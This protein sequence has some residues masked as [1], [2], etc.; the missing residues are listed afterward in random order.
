VT[1]REWTGAAKNVDAA[2]L[3]GLKALNLARHQVDVKVLGEKPS[4]LFSLFGFKQMEVRLTVKPGAL[5]ERDRFD[6][7][8]DRFR[9]R[10]RDGRSGR[11]DGDDRFE[12]RPRRG[13]KPRDRDDRANTKPQRQGQNNNRPD[14]PQKNDGRPK[15]TP[16]PQEKQRDGRDKPRNDRKPQPPRKDNRPPADTGA[17]KAPRDVPTADAILSQWKPLLGWDD[18]TWTTTSTDGKENI[19]FSGESEDRLMARDGAVLEALDHLVNT[20]RIRGDRDVPR[21]IFL[22]EGQ[23]APSEENIVSAALHA[24]DEVKQTGR[25][26]RL[27]PMPP[28]ERRIVHQTLANHPGVE[29]TSEGEGPF[30]KVVVKP[31]LK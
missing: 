12:K 26:Y 8:R 10:D 6:D 3:K 28:E 13:D 31:K 24:A 14:R 27:D 4:G 18:L 9:D 23:E 19:V 29:T 25:P 1:P 30:R 7:R 2:V 20:V 17:P 11:N 15:Q 22:M 16:P 21:S 5:V